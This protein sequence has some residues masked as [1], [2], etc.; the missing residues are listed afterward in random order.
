MQMCNILSSLKKPS[1]IGSVVKPHL[2]EE[3]LINKHC[4]HGSVNKP[5]GSVSVMAWPCHTRVSMLSCENLKGHRE[6]TAE[7]GSLI[8]AQQPRTSFSD[9]QLLCLSSLPFVSHWLDFCLTVCLHPP[10]PCMSTS[11]SKHMSL[12]LVNNLLEEANEKC[13]G[14][15]GEK[16]RGLSRG[17]LPVGATRKWDTREGD[18]K[19]EK[20]GKMMWQRTIRDLCS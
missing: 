16:F 14:L 1:S 2:S 19:V 6:S 17:L 10:L 18:T 13:A 7:G 9:S 15:L 20:E 3:M 5:R 11:E 8:L 4:H 12:H